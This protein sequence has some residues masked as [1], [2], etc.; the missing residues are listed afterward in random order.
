VAEYWTLYNKQKQESGKKVHTWAGR[1]MATGLPFVIYL[2]CRGSAGVCR[3]TEGLCEINEKKK[4]DTTLVK[5]LLG[6]AQANKYIL[7][8]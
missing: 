8:K 6:G 3:N 5:V 1:R 7:N 2:P 4:R